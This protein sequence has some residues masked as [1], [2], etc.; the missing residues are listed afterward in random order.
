[1]IAVATILWAVLAETLLS[2]SASESGWAIDFSPDPLQRDT[3]LA[4]A[5]ILGGVAVWSQKAAKVALI[6]FACL[7]PL[8]EFQ[9]WVVASR[10]NPFD[11]TEPAVP[12]IGAVVLFSGIVLWWRRASSIMI[13]ALAPAYVL[14]EFLIWHI[15]SNRLKDAADVAKLNPPTLLN[16][17]LQG[18]H[19][20]HV[21]VF[22]SS[23]LMM[24]WQMKLLLKEEK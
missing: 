23:A 9:S 19:W 6:V 3:R 22:L 11:R 4:L 14:F 2:E 8:L 12:V 21:V 20:W 15:E 5:L 17:L 10:Y 16:N 18:A 24:L 1:M 7:Y 13:S